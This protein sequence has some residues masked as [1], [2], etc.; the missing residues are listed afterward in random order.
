LKTGHRWRSPVPTLGLVLFNNFIND[1]DEGIEYTLSKFAD[2]TMLGRSIDV[3][4]GRK[5]LQKDLDRLDQWAEANCRRLNK[6]DCQVLHL[7]HNSPMKHYR[8]G[9]EWLESCPA[10]KDS[11]VLV[12]RSLNMSQ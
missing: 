6:V 12:N 3:L 7:G 1:L 11:G 8:L 10:E 5:V 4:E 2:D 9:E